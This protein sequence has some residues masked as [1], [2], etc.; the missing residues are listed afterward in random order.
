V[1][2]D[3]LKLLPRKQTEGQVRIGIRLLE[4]ENKAIPDTHSTADMN[5]IWHNPHYNLL[6]QMG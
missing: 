1:S 4:T 6:I 3:T 5:R 2:K